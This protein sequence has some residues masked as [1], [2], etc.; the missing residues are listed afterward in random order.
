MIGTRLVSRGFMRVTR[1]RPC[2]I[3]GKP[4]WCTYTRDEEVSICARQT[5]GANKINAHGEGIFVHEER[6]LNKHVFIP[7]PK[8]PEKHRAPIEVRDAVYRELLRLS[9]ATNYT[10]A[11]VEG[12]DGLLARG[13]QLNQ[14]S[15]FGALP[16]EIEAR[17]DLAHL[18]LKHVQKRFS[19]TIALDGVPGFWRD[20]L[21]IHL[22]KPKTYRAP[23]LLIPYRDAGGRIQALQMRRAKRHGD[24][25]S[26]YLWLSSCEEP[27]GA[28]SGTP[29]HHTFLDR[30]CPEDRVRVIT[31][32]ALKAEALVAL[33]PNAFALA[34]GGVSVA[35]QEL[36]SAT[37]GRQVLLAFDQDYHSNRV[38]CLQMASLIASRVAAERIHSSTRIALWDARF[39]GIDDAALAQVKI[40]SLS[41]S[42]WVER[43]SAEFREFVNKRWAESDV[44]ILPAS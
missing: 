10:P 28:S 37:R 5:V 41:I 18:L 44:Q 16:P 3:C 9:P 1:R 40:T 12:P 20:S 34:T 19:S 15:S 42:E 21:G 38:V 27:G 17:D 24:Q 30:N 23:R 22:W 14:L 13:F 36:I 4:D 2:R 35:H 11:L 39:K 6:D 31:E 26:H 43:L 25:G 33:R 7:A 8:S 32:G 29:L